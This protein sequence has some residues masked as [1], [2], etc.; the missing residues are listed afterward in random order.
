MNQKS[1]PLESDTTVAGFS[2]AH[3]HH[4]PARNPFNGRILMVCSPRIDWN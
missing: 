4:P 1:L 2:L 3:P